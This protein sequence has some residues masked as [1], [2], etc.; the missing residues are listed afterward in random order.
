MPQGY[1]LLCAQLLTVTA[2]VAAF[3][4]TIYAVTPKLV[5]ALGNVSILD[6]I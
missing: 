1:R 3:G 2:Q 4:A 6:S 5:I